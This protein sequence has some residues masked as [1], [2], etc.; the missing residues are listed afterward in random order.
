MER[1]WQ[2]RGLKCNKKQINIVNFFV[3]VSVALH[4]LISA[5]KKLKMQKEGE[6]EKN[7]DKNPSGQ[8]WKISIH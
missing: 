6:G 3:G 5:E 1:I 4:F 8:N 7:E 2:L